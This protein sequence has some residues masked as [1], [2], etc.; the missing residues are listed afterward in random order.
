MN[1][2]R[3]LRILCVTLGFFQACKKAPQ[4]DET[5]S[6]ISPLAIEEIPNPV[7]DLIRS[8]DINQDLQKAFKRRFLKGIK[9]Q[10]PE[11]IKSAFVPTS[12]GQFYVPKES[13][14]QN[15]DGIYHWSTKSAAGEYLSVDQLTQALM[16]MLTNWASVDLVDWHVFR[17]RADTRRPSSRATVRGH[18]SLAGT[19]S[20]GQRDELYAS[21][22][23]EFVRNE[24]GHWRISKMR[25]DDQT[26]ARTNA[27]R[28]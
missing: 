6:N 21:V 17:V 25:F 20:N 7:R 11:K 12:K 27:P 24:K 13:E 10:S 14:Y 16:K 9:N 1:A 4:G 23:C 3:N 28:L 5:P 8:E 2:S 18:L 19:W 26:R 15:D 22:T